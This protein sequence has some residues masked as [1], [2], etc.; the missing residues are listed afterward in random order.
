MT[1]LVALYCSRTGSIRRL[2][3]DACA[4]YMRAGGQA[5]LVD[6]T[7]FDRGQVAAQLAAADACLFAAPTHLGGPAVEFVRF[8]EWT[9]SLRAGRVL[10]NCWAGGLTSGMAWDGG[11]TGTLQYFLS[12][13][14][15]HSMVWAGLDEPAT[16]VCV[17][18]ER[19][20]RNREGA[21]IGA[22]ATV[23]EGVLTQSSL[24]TA[25]ALGVRLLK[26]GGRPGVDTRQVE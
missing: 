16:N 24:H 8:A 13:A 18:G 21:R 5:R 12:L 15:Q 26:L 11:K 3:E 4:A 10:A 6:V 17:E 23:A 25:R 22:S 2:V 7:R 19:V 9:S 1:Q 14:L 20:V